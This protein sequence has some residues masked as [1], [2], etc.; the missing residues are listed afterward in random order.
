M[1]RKKRADREAE[2]GSQA[3]EGATEQRRQQSITGQRGESIVTSPKTPCGLF[4][5]RNASITRLICMNH[6]FSMME[7]MMMMMMITVILTTTSWQAFAVKMPRRR[8][9]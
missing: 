5:G 7:M 1:N 3:A 2:T 9:E 8:R 6:V 4:S